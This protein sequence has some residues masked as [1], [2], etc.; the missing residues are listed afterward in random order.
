MDPPTPGRHGVVLLGLHEAQLRQ[1][2]Q[3]VAQDFKL[4]AGPLLFGRA[5]RP[6]G[7]LPWIHFL[8]K[9]DLYFPTKL[10]QLPHKH[11]VLEQGIY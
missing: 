9:S 6:L 3:K 4:P 10:L 1:N 11:Q 8:R 7:R 5:F 2:H